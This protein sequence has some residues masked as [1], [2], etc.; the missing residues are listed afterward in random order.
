MERF[1]D[2]VRLDGV[3]LLLVRPWLA[4]VCGFALINYR[5]Y[6]GHLLKDGM[7]LGQ[8]FRVAP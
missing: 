2:G 7:I 1:P 3:V 4:G 6:A 5:L 8:I